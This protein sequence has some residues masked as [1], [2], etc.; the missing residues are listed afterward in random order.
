M[1]RVV[2]AADRCVRSALRFFFSEH[3]EVPVGVVRAQA[4]RDAGAGEE[5]AAD[6]PERQVV[7]TRLAAGTRERERLALEGVGQA[8]EG[9][10]ESHEALPEGCVGE[11]ERR[12]DL[13]AVH[14]V[15]CQDNNAA[16]RSGKGAQP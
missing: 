7:G 14:P 4:R 1:Y 8:A 6:E 9:T 11:T 3:Q 13:V 12:T 16:R 5:G 15:Q 2:A 10:A